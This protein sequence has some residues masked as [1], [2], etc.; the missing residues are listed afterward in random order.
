MFDIAKP[1]LG[2][3]M[4][5][6]MDDKLIDSVLERWRTTYDG[7]VLLVQDLTTINVTP[8]QIVAR[9]AKADLLAWPP[10]PSASR[11]R[12]EAWPAERGA[13]TVLAHRDE[14]LAGTVVPRGVGRMG[15]GGNRT[16]ASNWTR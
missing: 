3:G 1:R 15:N 10:P 8:D 9:Q 5:Y 16:T 14:D 12:L 13:K 4:H 11:G 6:P 2:V 7:P